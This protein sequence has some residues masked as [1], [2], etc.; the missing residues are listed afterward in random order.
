MIYGCAGDVIDPGSFQG[1]LRLYIQYV[2]CR[3]DTAGRLDRSWR[4]VRDA[5]RQGTAPSV[6]GV[7]YDLQARDRSSILFAITRLNVPGRFV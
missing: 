5:E 4:V 7:T 6:D 2:T 1:A 3:S